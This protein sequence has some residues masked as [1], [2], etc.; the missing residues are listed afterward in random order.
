MSLQRA[1]IDRGIEVFTSATAVLSEQEEKVI[2]SSIDGDVICERPADLVVVAVG[3][4]SCKLAELSTEN[5]ECPVI[6]VGDAI[7]P[8]GIWEATHEGSY[9]ILQI[10]RL[11]DI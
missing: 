5:L 6:N 11:N 7:R 1:L 8:R 10:E 3:A 4:N 9:A 2:I